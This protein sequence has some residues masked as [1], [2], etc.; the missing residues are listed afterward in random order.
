MKTLSDI[1]TTLQQEAKT[2]ATFVRRVELLQQ[3]S[4]E[5]TARDSA[6]QIRVAGDLTAS[7]ATGEYFVIPLDE[8]DGEH[9]IT[10]TPSYSIP[11]DETTIICSGSSF[12][13]AIVGL[14]IAKRHIVSFGNTERL[15]ELGSIRYELEGETLNDWTDADVDLHFENGDGW[16]ANTSGTGV[17]DN[18]DVFWARI[19]FGYKGATDRILYFGGLID[20]DE[21]DDDRYAR[22]FMLTAFGH[23]KELERYPGYLISNP[24]ADFLKISG[25]E[26]IS[27]EE[28][29]KTFAGVKELKW[30]LESRSIPGVELKSINRDAVPGVY[31]LRFRW[32]NLFKW[33]WGDWTAVN[34]NTSTATLT[35][36]DGSEL[37]ISTTY[38]DARDWDV[39]VEIDPLNNTQMKANGVFSLQFDNGA[40]CDIRQDFSAIITDAG[41]TVYSNSSNDNDAP[42]GSYVCLGA[43]DAAIY[44]YSEV[45][46][47][48]I[49]V[50]LAASDLVGTIR[51][52]YSAGFSAWTAIASITDGTSNMT[53]SAAITWVKDQVPGWRETTVDPGGSIEDVRQKYGLRIDLTAYTSGSATVLNIRKYL[54]MYSANGAC[55]N[56]MMDL[57]NLTLGTDSEEVI[58]R[59]INSVWTLCTWYTNMTFQT[60]V[61]AILAAAN[62]GSSY[63]TLDDLKIEAAMP[64]ISII[65]RAPKPYYNKR[66]TAVCYDSANDVI[67]LGIENELWK[68]TEAGDFSLV[69]SIPL[70]VN[71]S[72]SIK[73]LEVYGSYIYGLAWY[74]DHE[75]V[76]IDPWYNN[77]EPGTLVKVFKADST[78]FLELHDIGHGDEYIWPCDKLLRK[79]SIY[80]LSSVDH[81]F[82]GQRT[83]YES[84]ENLF[85]PFPQILKPNGANQLRWY[86]AQGLIT[87]TFSLVYDTITGKYYNVKTGYY[88]E[89]D[90][91]VLEFMDYWDNLRFM[92]GNTGFMVWYP[93]VWVGYQMQRDNGAH[94]DTSVKIGEI[95]DD[96]SFASKRDVADSSI[97]P[98]CGVCVSGDLYY[99][100]IAWDDAGTDLSVCELRK[101]V[102]SSSTDSLVWSC[103][104]DSAETGQSIT[105]IEATQTILELAYNS[106]EGTLH[107]CMLDRATFQYHYFVYKI[108]TD[109]MYSTQTGF[110]FTFDKH[111]QI[112]NFAFYN[113][114]IYAVVVDKRYSTDGIYLVD[115]VFNS[116]TET[117]TISYIDMID[118]TD[119][120][121]V[122]L[123]SSSEGLF[124]LS[125]KGLLWKYGTSFYPR[126]GLA[127]LG[128]DDLRKVLGNCAQALNRILFVKPDRHL[129]MITR[130]SDGTAKTLY[131]DIHWHAL[132]PL[133]PWPHYYDRVEVNWED[134]ATGQKGMEAQG[135]DGWQRRVLKIDNKLIQNRF[136]ARVIATQYHTYFNRRGYV[137]ECEAIPL[138]QLDIYDR[139]RFILNSAATDLDRND[140]Y[141]LMYLD[142]DSENLVLTAQGV[143]HASVG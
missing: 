131:E 61:N 13:I 74:D 21:T 124:G 11:N 110:N 107:G 23:L 97:Q 7:L 132:K 91:G 33:A 42:D 45:P 53:G 112:K 104:S 86:D 113:D 10:S 88:M 85:I 3:F 72:V 99:A 12:N 17:F 83:G 52:S 68:V 76:V 69:A 106:I 139:I 67:W 87:S 48:G 81:R 15:V 43:S 30:S 37:K 65:G 126:I 129:S 82:V 122:Q 9:V 109:K 133:K 103:A 111:R 18:S 36:A 41:S 58:L 134:P 130:D 136:L 78:G 114:K 49:E 60:L 71:L 120:D 93:T 75:K 20:F 89:D 140:Y 138:I 137:A 80:D 14:N 98:L 57:H 142:F 35:G 135:A 125:G 84:G 40:P 27:I 123:I 95:F 44:L 24:N 29:D 6:T 119:F 77:Q 38:Y 46:F 105:G 66:A 127:N 26:I 19:Y 92:L 62:Y 118:E 22:A 79:G 50:N 16:F 141:K 128:D 70:L 100:Q 115:V 121:H 32:P 117:I 5:I 47:Y 63:Y 108:S 143:H 64:E 39:W 2:N 55:V 56:F 28:S 51:L 116:G 34:E 31:P 101:L 1:N 54:R 96:G 8:F 90:P 94:T 59:Q 25:L 4:G 73:R 102:L